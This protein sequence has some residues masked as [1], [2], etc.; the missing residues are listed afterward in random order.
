[1]GAQVV[2]RQE[3]TSIYAATD[4]GFDNVNWKTQWLYN[5]RKTDT[6]SYRQFF[7]LIAGGYDP[8]LGYD[9]RY[10]NDPDYRAPVASGVAQPIMPFPSDASV[11]VDYFYGATKFDGLIGGTDTWAWEGNATYTRSKGVY[12]VLSIIAS[13]TGD[14]EYSDDAPTLDYFDPGF[15][16]GARMGELVDA[17]GQWHRGETVYDQTMVNAIVSGELFE[18]PAGGVGAAFG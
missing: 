8:D 6:Q 7:P 9:Y 2:D 18:V 5:K 3:R 1:N 17:I 11:T 16:S 10:G 14:W 15:L 12:D 4:F 13:R